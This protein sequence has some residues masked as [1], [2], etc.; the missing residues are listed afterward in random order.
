MANIDDTKQK[1]K[2]YY[3]TVKGWKPSNNPNAQVV[4]ISK[5]GKQIGETSTSQTIEP[6]S[7]QIP[8]QPIQQSK[9][10]IFEQAQQPVSQQWKN[11]IQ[12]STT[13]TPREAWER[14]LA[15]PSPKEQ[16]PQVSSISPNQPSLVSDVKRPATVLSNVAG[17]VK[18]GMT[19]RTDMSKQL[20][21]QMPYET[22]GTVST[23]PRLTYEQFYKQELLG[24]GANE[25]IQYGTE[26]IRRKT[27]EPFSAELESGTQKI[28]NDINVGLITLEEGK[29]KGNILLE[30]INKRYSS[31]TE[32]K[33]SQYYT[34]RGFAE[35]RKPV[36]DTSLLRGA[37]V[38][39]TGVLL[40]LGLTPGLTPGLLITRGLQIAGMYEFTKTSGLLWGG[41]ELTKKERLS[42]FGKQSIA[43][44]QVALG[45]M[46]ES[47]EALKFEFS[48]QLNKELQKLPD[49]NL[50][51]PLKEIQLREG[52]V[53]E[54]QMMGTRGAGPFKQE[55]YMEGKFLGTEGGKIFM[56]SGKGGVVT[57]GINV[58]NYAQLDLPKKVYTNIETFNTGLKGIA[59]PESETSF[60][61]FAKGTYELE[62]ST[63]VL[64][65]MPK[66]FDAKFFTGLRREAISNLQTYEG[67]YR[68]VPLAG[69]S[70]QLT[71]EGDLFI[72]KS[73][74]ITNIYAESNVKLDIIQNEKI[75]RN[76]YNYGYDVEPQLF[77]RKDV[78]G[79]II[80][81][82]KYI[83][84]TPDI[85]IE[86]QIE[87]YLHERGHLLGKEFYKHG[88]KG[89]TSK[90]LSLMKKE[91]SGYFEDIKELGYPKNQYFSESFARA[92]SQGAL[93][94]YAGEKF[95]INTEKFPTYSKYI[96]PIFDKELSRLPSKEIIKSQIQ[97]TRTIEKPLSLNVQFPEQMII[98]SELKDISITKIIPKSKVEN[99]FEITSGGR[100][101]SL[102]GFA[103]D[104]K[105]AGLTK[106]VI[107]ESLKQSAVK[108]PSQSSISK[109]LGSMF[110][111]GQF[112]TTTKEKPVGQFGTSQKIL[113][114]TK[115]K[116]RQISSFPNLGSLTK[117]KLSSGLE[118]RE[119]L[120][121]PQLVSQSLLTG[122]VLKERQLNI[123]KLTT[124]FNPPS[125][126]PPFRGFGFDTTFTPPFVSLTMPGL[127]E[128]GV[129]RKRKKKKRRSISVAPSFTAEVFGLTG[130]FPE[131]SAFGISPFNLR[132]LPKGYKGLT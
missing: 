72:T 62:S 130:K 83:G 82:K 102:K 47:S 80:Y 88:L 40:T 75:L 38:V 121:S 108:L 109:S 97:G 52:Q 78:L 94:K 13:P 84:I 25:P 129:P 87:T 18:G 122:Q 41:K 59:V 120:V 30:D 89:V 86:R 124:G 26:R 112:G 36:V 44:T 131:S 21:P 81:N 42:L 93:R 123:S 28:Q 116:E 79:E 29:K 5:S 63:T 90:D 68:Q 95:L 67:K 55:L 2:V 4:Y 20:F 99:I 74:K 33:L 51:N 17:F 110:G 132:V 7:T 10:S 117:T 50:K 57:T 73:G 35:S 111:V 69:I 101:A 70:Q 34:L 66:K 24:A 16:G 32:Q 85:K 58:P 11:L 43:L 6:A 119:R 77:L 118:N 56:P 115:L 12:Q 8:V 125:T 45:A 113:Q 53:I 114:V 92:F 128:F 127:F 126:P 61:I 107:Q 106:Q 39:A 54:S 105:S 27:G 76:I 48:L 49:F 46:A 64:K 71:K 1:P 60:N 96:Q 104:L 98:K 14:Y 103:V 91:L 100:T 23:A 22:R 3:S 15:Q 65:N 19:V 31:V 9:P 37:E